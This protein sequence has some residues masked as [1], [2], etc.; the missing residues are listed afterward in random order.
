MTS[1]EFSPARYEA[2]EDDAGVRLDRFLASRIETQSRVRLQDL[3]RAGHVVRLAAGRDAEAST[4]PS[5]KVRLGDT[6]EVTTP[7]AEDYAVEG[8]AIELN[9]VYEDAS[10]I[11]IDKPAGLVVHPGAGNP[12]GTLVNA[13]IAHCGDSLSGIGGVTRPGIVHRLDK[14][15]SGLMVVAKTDKA[16]RSLS[17]QFADHGRTGALRRE[18]L[19]L[20]WGEPQPTSGRIEARIARHP[21]S[22]IK[23]AVVRN[24]GREAATIY[25]IERVFRLGN[26]ESQSAATGKWNKTATLSVLRCKLETGRTHQVRVHLAHIGVPLVGDS[27]YGAGFRTKALALPDEAA[28]NFACAERQALHAAGLRFE[29]PSSRKVLSF[30]SPLPEDIAQLCN[31]LERFDAKLSKN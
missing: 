5:A 4:D 11:V 27:V 19:A 31:A 9:V 6:F 7:P 13:L 28:R 2:S 26:V 30:E 24:G 17:A 15:T 25:A 21:G 10:L 14:N 1:D 18:Y 8:E 12:N 3:I 16:H 22:R 29:H 23:M 20:V